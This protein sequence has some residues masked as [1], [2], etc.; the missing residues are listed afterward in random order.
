MLRSS[1]FSATATT[2]P[3]LCSRAPAAPFL[4]RSLTTSRYASVSPT[5]KADAGVTKGLEGPHPN[6]ERLSK[7][8]TTPVHFK[9]K[10]V[11]ATST[12]TSAMPIGDWVVHR[13]AK[14]ISD[15]AAQFFVKCL[16]TG[17]DLVSGY[18]HKPMTPEASRLS[19]EEMRKQGYAMTAEQWLM[20][21]IFLETVAGV[22][23]MVAGTLRHLRSLRM[24]RRDGGWIHTL[25][26]ESE[27]ERMHLMTFMTLKKPSIIFRACVLGAQ[28]IFYN[29]FFLGYLV[30]PKTAHRFVGHLEEEAVK[31]YTLAIE[32]LEQ[33]RIPEWSDTPAPEIAIDYW[34]MTQDAKLVDVFRNIRADEATH[35][36]VNH[37]LANLNQREDVNPFAL[38]EPNMTLK[39]TSVGL[40]RPEAAEF[41]KST[42][43]ILSEGRTSDAALEKA[44]P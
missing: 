38:R 29:A 27:N 19:L 28:G 26:E 6:D 7:A 34:R 37:S 12:F 2:R 32:D 14:T 4:L 17:F 10:P 18:K 9:G 8:H 20:R 23:G 13:D 35:R 41:V 40:E 25:L 43:H 30:S 24:M 15:K 21:C 16:R 22:P 36:F 31:T 11:D 5:A 1:I 39:G 44:Q 3:I 42:Q 33:G